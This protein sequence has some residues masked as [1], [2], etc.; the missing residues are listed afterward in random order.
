M[1]ADPG[2]LSRTLTE[3]A[4][5]L[6]EADLEFVVSEF[7]TTTELDVGGTG[8]DKRVP[9]NVQRQELHFAGR[10]AAMFRWVGFCLEVN[11]R[12]FFSASG[13][14]TASGRARP[15]AEGP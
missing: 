11:Y 5:R 4:A 10:Y 1:G 8:E 6:Q 12:D 13:T 9:L 14:S 3:L 7:G 2:T 15:E